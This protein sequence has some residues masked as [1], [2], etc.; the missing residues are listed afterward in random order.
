[1]TR[2]RVAV[3]ISG[4][5]SNLQALLDACAAPDYPAQIVLVISNKPLAYGLTRAA[6]AGVPTRVIEHHAYDSRDAFDAALQ[7]SLVEYAAEYVCLA[8]FM[9]LLT[10]AFTQAWAGRMLNIHPSLLPAYKGLDTHRRVLADGETESGCTVH[11][12]TPELDDGPIILQAR[13]PVIAGDTPESLQQRIHLEEHRIYPLALRR[14]IED[15][16]AAGAR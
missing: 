14:L 4:N 1:V 16:Q 8:G 9:R 10:P 6:Q 7:A 15:T 11:L 12:V 2:A 3:L 13:V 5:G